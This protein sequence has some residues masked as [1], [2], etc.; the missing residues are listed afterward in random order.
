MLR[1]K[2]AF[3][4]AILAAILALAGLWAAANAQNQNYRFEAVNDRIPVGKAVRIEVRLLGPNAKPVPAENI[5]L[6]T[7]QPYHHQTKDD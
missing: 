5:T 2:T 7:T 3:A 6:Q 1:S 4:A